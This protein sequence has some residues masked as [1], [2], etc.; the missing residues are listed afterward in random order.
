MEIVKIVIA[1]I[2][3]KI[4]IAFVSF[5]VCVVLAWLE[6]RTT[7][8]SRKG[9]NKRSSVQNFSKADSLPNLRT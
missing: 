1:V 2:I 8:K 4:I 5:I 6:L 7:M 3:A 9:G